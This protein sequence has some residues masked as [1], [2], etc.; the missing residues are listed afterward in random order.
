MH[1]SLAINAINAYSATSAVRPMN[2]SVKNQS[3]VSSAYTES[4]KGVKKTGTFPNIGAVNPVQYPNAQVTAVDPTEKLAKAQSV[5]RDMNEI[6]SEFTGTATGYNSA[7]QSY[8]YDTIG[9]T[10]DVYI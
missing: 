4:T 8:G 1:M 9:S 3:D 2:Y 6:A 7:S 10:I 5:S